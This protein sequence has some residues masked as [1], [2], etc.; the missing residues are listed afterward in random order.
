MT[1]GRA[2]YSLAPV[3]PRGIPPL[4]ECAHE[5]D[6]YDKLEGIAG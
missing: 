2:Q 6:V 4:L 1:L 5:A 3:L